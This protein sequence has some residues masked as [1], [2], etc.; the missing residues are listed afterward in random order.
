[1]HSLIDVFPWSA[2]S[3]SK[4]PLSPNEGAL[5]GSRSELLLVC[6]SGRWHQTHGTGNA[7]R[8]EMGTEDW[9]PKVFWNQYRNKWWHNG[10]QRNMKSSSGLEKKL[11]EKWLQWRLENIPQGLTF[12]RLNE[13]KPLRL[14]KISLLWW[15]AVWPGWGERSHTVVSP[16]IAHFP[17]QGRDPRDASWA[18]RAQNL[19]RHY[20]FKETLGYLRYHSERDLP[21]MQIWVPQRRS[22]KA[23]GLTEVLLPFLGIYKPSGEL[24]KIKCRF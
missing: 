16:F 18:L 21:T 11:L 2:H 19:R 15:E 20:K 24:L 9:T 7:S 1:M 22:P 5:F 10:Q 13:N 23:L 8:G 4:V 6:W 12:R 14:L 3:W 17:Y